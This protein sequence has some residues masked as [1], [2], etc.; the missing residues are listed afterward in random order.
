MHAMRMAQFDFWQVQP[1]GFLLIRRDLAAAA[2]S[3]RSN[4]CRTTDQVQ[5]LAGA[6]PLVSGFNQYP[7]G[8]L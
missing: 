7:R 8:L 1:R 6:A 3:A 5:A 2:G 4:Y